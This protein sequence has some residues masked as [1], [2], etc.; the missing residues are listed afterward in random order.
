MKKWMDKDSKDIKKKL[1]LW[2]KQMVDSLEV[3]YVGTIS[4]EDFKLFL[5]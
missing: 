1:D 5:T 2:Y 4:M 3:A